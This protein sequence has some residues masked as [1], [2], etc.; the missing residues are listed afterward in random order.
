MMIQLFAAAAMLSQPIPAPRDYVTQNYDLRF[1]SPAHTTICPM[2]DGWVGSDHGTVIFLSPPAQCGG[3]GYASSDRGSTPDMPRIEVYYGYWLGE[4]EPRRTCRAAGWARLIGRRRRICR[5][6]QEGDVRIEARALYH[7]DSEAEVDVA[8]VTTPAR[9][10][11]DLRRFQAFVVRVRTCS[12]TWFDK[13]GAH[14]AGSGPA[15]PPTHWW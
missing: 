5:S 7:T 11:G 3:Y 2:P 10:A 13:S 6:D 8:L 15:C 14:V 1:P 9:L 4:D 12:V